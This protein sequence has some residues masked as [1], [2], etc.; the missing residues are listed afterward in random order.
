MAAKNSGNTPRIEVALAIGAEWNQSVQNIKNEFEKTFSKPLEVNVDLNRKAFDVKLADV[1]SDLEALSTSK[2][3]KLD[4]DDA[5]AVE[6]VK[7]IGAQLS[8]YFT[9]NIKPINLDDMLN[10]DNAVSNLKELTGELKGLTT[11]YKQLLQV[12]SNLNR[13]G[14]QM[15]AEQAT[16]KQIH[17]MTGGI[18][19]FITRLNSLSKAYTKFY[20]A[21]DGKKLTPHDYGNAL[22][23]QL[24]KMS[25][26]GKIEVGFI[27]A[28]SPETKA[29][30]K[31]E[32]S[33]LSSELNAE[34]ARIKVQ[35]ELVDYKSIDEQTKASPIPIS[36]YPRIDLDDIF[37]SRLQSE[38]SSLNKAIKGS[39]AYQIKLGISE[40]SV[41]DLKSI[42]ETLS[43]GTDKNIKSPFDLNL[44]K[45]TQ[46]AIGNI[47]KLNK[48]LKELSDPSRQKIDLTGLTASLGE[49]KNIDAFKELG[50][51]LND[52]SSESAKAI[53]DGVS[54]AVKVLEERVEKFNV[55]NDD[56][57][58]ININLSDDAKAAAAAIINLATALLKLS[59]IKK[60]DIDFTKI[61]DSLNS[62]K[63]NGEL[64]EMLDILENIANVSDRFEAIANAVKSIASD[65]G[66]FNKVIKQVPAEK[67]SVKKDASDEKRAAEKSNKETQAN[68]KGREKI[69]TDLAALKSVY[70]TF[71][72]IDTRTTNN[73]FR[74][75][76]KSVDEFSDNF[77]NVETTIDKVREALNKGDLKTAADELNKIGFKNVINN[78][79]AAIKELQGVEKKLKEVKELYAKTDSDGK[80]IGVNNQPFEQQFAAMVNLRS[81]LQNLKKTM[82]DVKLDEMGFKDK[83]DEDGNNITK[84]QQFEAQ[85]DAYI[86]EI[87]KAE[88]KV[89][90]ALKGFQKTVKDGTANDGTIKGVADAMDDVQ[91][92]GDGTVKKLKALRAEGERDVKV[93]ERAQKAIMN[94]QN[95]LEN[96][97]IKN[98]V[99][100]TQLKQLLN[101]ANANT[102]SE[103]AGISAELARINQQIR[104]AG[105]AVDTFGNKL[106]R[107]FSA[108][109]RAAIS[110][111]GMFLVGQGFREI[112]QNVK[113]VDAAMTELRKVTDATNSEFIA[114]LD[115]ATNRAQKL[116]GSLADVVSAT[117]D[118]SRLGYSLEEATDLADV[119]IMSKNVWDDVDNIDDVTSSLI[120]TMKGFRIEAE[121]AIEISDKF[122]EVANNW[123]TSAGA[124]SEGMLRSASALSAAGNTL[125]QGIALFTAGQSVVQ[126]AESMGTILKTTTMRIRGKVCAHYKEIYRPLTQY[127]KVA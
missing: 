113:E 46:A 42:K 68:Q 34:G 123:P 36:V 114:F 17:S 99:F 69:D 84:R 73:P 65:A 7:S 112:Y 76:I 3:I 85:V 33:A 26:V 91:L 63:G 53:L 75:A 87:N 25:E 103:T 80:I 39:P 125:D 43:Q 116:G 24:Q 62:F 32:L 51:T 72:D 117:A 92:A 55:K 74:G 41:N 48:A 97:R 16:E 78:G 104:A 54:E 70:N 57:S 47:S 83:V 21:A 64:K 18:E 1:R 60:E 2:V 121:N 19:A 126:N 101:R 90:T 81:N 38:I 96:P 12:S 20:E 120:S 44:S 71:K 106:I 11:E 105:L 95:A 4:I 14:K 82:P 28:L 79:K 5:K 100:E 61:L 56:G 59:K 23:E 6:S 50:T 122:N 66:A 22:V 67:R 35:A 118:Y 52:L 88:A 127:K 13:A 40:A 108:R 89:K 77:S 98:T 30:I 37:K 111:S 110:G 27:G 10:A 102:G 93:A 49:L 58:L 8:K 115:G 86:I 45:E 15:A 124:I 9:D 109:L 31:S 107:T 29:S 94:I 119:A